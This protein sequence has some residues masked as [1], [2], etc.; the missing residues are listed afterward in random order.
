MEEKGVKPKKK[1][2]EGEREWE[3]KGERH[4]G[5]NE[6][7]REVEERRDGGSENERA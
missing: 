3:G 4:G 1:V 2:S 6:E 5:R 7:R